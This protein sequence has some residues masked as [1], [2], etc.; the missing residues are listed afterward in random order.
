ML[1]VATIVIDNGDDD[2]DDAGGR[3]VN[4]VIVMMSMMLNVMLNAMAVWTEVAQN[5]SL[6]GL[7][8]SSFGRGQ[9]HRLRDSI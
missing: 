8:S 2:D 5:L 3:H 9:S 4:A 6:G 7:G 1:M